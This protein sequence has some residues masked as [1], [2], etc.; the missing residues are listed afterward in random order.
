[1]AMPRCL[2]VDSCYPD[3]ILCRGGVES[4]VRDRI[5]GAGV[6]GGNWQAS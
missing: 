1:M 3:V 4:T 5:S 6:N 2:E